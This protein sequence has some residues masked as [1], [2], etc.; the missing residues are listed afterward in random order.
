LSALSA[1]YGA[2]APG[3]VRLDDRERVLRL[4]AFPRGT[5]EGRFGS[6]G[7]Y[8]SV[9]A[10]GRWTLAVRAERRSTVTLEASLRTLSAP[11]EPCAVLVNR[12]HLPDDAWSFDPS[13][14]VLRTT[15]EGRSIR[16]EAQACP[17]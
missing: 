16:V 17:G 11:F 15:V 13:T 4:L 8:T 9:E 3:L 10:P 7:R 5:S 6:K 12:R 1:D 2:G 14:G